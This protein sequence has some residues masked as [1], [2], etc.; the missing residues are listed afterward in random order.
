[1][2][3]EWLISCNKKSSLTTVSAE[4]KL[5]LNYLLRLFVNPADIAK[6]DYDIE[7]CVP[8]KVLQDYFT[9]K[10]IAVPISA[11]CNL[12]YIPKSENRGKGDM[13][14]YQKQKKD[15]SS[16]TLNETALEALNYPRKKDLVFVESVSTLTAKNYFLFL[17]EREKYITHRMITKLYE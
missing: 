14:Y 13:T 16:Y 11:A 2:I 6:T 5:F 17:S 10:N 8:K 1:M 12:V 4:T 3:S 9:K 7:H 15:A